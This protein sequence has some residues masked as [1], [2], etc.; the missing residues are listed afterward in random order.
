M[1]L[2]IKYPS[3]PNYDVDQIQTNGEIE[4][5]ITQIQTILFTDSGEVMGDHKFGCDLESL[6]YDFNSSEH[7]IK[8]VIVDQLNAYCP[9]ASKYDVAVNVDFVQGEVRDIAFIDITID[10]R[11]AIKISML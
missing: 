10:S 7:N 8:S 5:L 4:M 6:I 1:E 11:Y 9:L 2:Y 3:D